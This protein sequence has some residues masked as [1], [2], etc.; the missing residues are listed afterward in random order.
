MKKNIPEDEAAACFN[1]KSDESEL[2]R[3]SIMYNCW[4]IFTV[5]LFPILWFFIIYFFNF[6]V[7]LLSSYLIQCRFMIL[8]AP[9]LSINNY[10]FVY[11]FF[12]A[13]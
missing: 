10:L 1:E 12:K 6:N 9:G 13:K 7:Y 11:G 2:T 3:S 5:A 4:N 8:G